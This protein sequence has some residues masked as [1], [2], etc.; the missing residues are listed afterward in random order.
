MG[1]NLSEVFDPQFGGA[2]SIVGELYFMLTMV[3]FLAIGG[4]LEMIRGFRASFDALPL[5]SL[6]VDQSLFDL[7]IKLFTG[8]ASFAIQ[9]AAPVLVTMVVV[10]LALGFIGKT[11]PQ[12]NVMS[13]G[14]TIRSLVGMMVLVMS[15]GLASR[16]MRQELASSLELVTRGFSGVLTK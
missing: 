6:G 2:S 16:V 7:L 11:I 1:L 5:L 15:V 4:H 8:A 9:L 14:L 12:F 3:I 13:A 10:D